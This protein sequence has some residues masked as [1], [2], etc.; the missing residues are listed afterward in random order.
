MKKRRS[1]VS[2]IGGADEPTSVF[3]ATKP[4]KYTFRQKFQRFKHQI[5]RKYVE[6]TLKCINHG[7]DEVFE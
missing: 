4:S 5:K 3:V 2:I 7:M 1:A 6:R